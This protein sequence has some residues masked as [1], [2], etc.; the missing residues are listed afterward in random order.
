IGGSL[1]GVDAGGRALRYLSGV[2][3]LH[4]ASGKSI[5]LVTLVINVLFVVILTVTAG[6]IF[7]ESWQ[8]RGEVPRGDTTIPGPL[9]TKVRI[10][11]FIDLPNVGIRQASVPLLAYLGFLLGFLSGIMGVGGG[12]LLMPVLMYG[13]GLSARNSAGTGVLLLF[14]TVSL[15]T[16]QSALSGHVSL[17]LAVTLLMGSSIG[18]QIGA[19]TTHRLPNRV[20]R[21]AFACLVGAAALAML[22]NALRLSNG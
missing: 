18:A 1:I 17:P 6:F 5:P 21:L 2:A 4:L 20:L 19:L 10:P 3:P 11:P 7:R 13:F 14:L 8:A 12:V 22:W 9:V 15:G 16:V